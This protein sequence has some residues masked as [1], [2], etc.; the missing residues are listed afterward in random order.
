MLKWLSMERGLWHM[1]QITT[2][3]ILV[4]SVI[5]MERSPRK[6]IGY[7]FMFK[8]FKGDQKDLSEGTFDLRVWLKRM[9]RHAAVEKLDAKKSTN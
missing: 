6:G 9:G 2:K 5:P 8:M 3:L 7:T 1:R 4:A